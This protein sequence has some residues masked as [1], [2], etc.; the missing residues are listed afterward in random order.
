M[1]V[2]EEVAVR[3]LIWSLPVE[4]SPEERVVMR[5]VKRAKLLVFLRERRHEIFEEAFQE[6]SGAIY[7]DGGATASAGPRSRRRGSPLPPSC[8]PIPAS[9]TMRLWK[10]R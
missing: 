7:H 5:L 9:T 6:E 8:R 10:Q 2:A 3:P 4:P 1:P